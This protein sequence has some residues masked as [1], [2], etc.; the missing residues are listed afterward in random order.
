[1]IAR[2]LECGWDCYRVD[3]RAATVEDRLKSMPKA[4]VA[5]L[6]R[7]EPDPFVRQYTRFRATGRCVSQKAF[8]YA[9][10]IFHARHTNLATATIKAMVIAGAK[11]SEIAEKLG[12]PAPSKWV[13]L[14]GFF[15]MLLNTGTIV[16]GWRP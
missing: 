5:E 2:T 4:S 15:L 1:M 9:Q 13:P 14:R 7:D 8:E 11:S 16:N 3:W 10:R 12:I 6:C